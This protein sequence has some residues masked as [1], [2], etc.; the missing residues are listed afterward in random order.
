MHPDESKVFALLCFVWFRL[1]VCCTF[2][3]IAFVLMDQANQHSRDV[4]C[5]I[6]TTP[7][8]SMWRLIVVTLLAFFPSRAVSSRGVRVRFNLLCVL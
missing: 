6:F 8:L 4:P 3:L 1:R 5:W 7:V 2:V